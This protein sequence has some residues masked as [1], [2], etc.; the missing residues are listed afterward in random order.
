MAIPII[1]AI[2]IIEDNSISGCYLMS[3]HNPLTFIVKATYTVAS[4]DTI[5]AKIG[6]EVYKCIYYGDESATERLFYFI[7]DEI[8]RADLGAIE[9][10]EQ[11]PDTIIHMANLS[12]D[13]TVTFTE[14]FGIH[15]ISDSVVISVVNAANDF[16]SANGAVMLSD[17]NNESKFYV[18]SKDKQIYLYWYNDNASNVVDGNTYPKG[19]LRKCLIFTECEI[20]TASIV[21]DSVTYTHTVNIKEWYD[22]SY[23]IKYLDRSGKY[24]FMPFNPFV[25]RQSNPVLIG[26]VNELVYS[27]YTSKSDKRSIGYKN[28]DTITMTALELN[29]NE[30]QYL[31]D[32][33]C[34]SDIQLLIGSKWVRV[35][36][37][38][39]NISYLP[40]RRTK[41]VVITVNLP[42]SY[43]I[44]EL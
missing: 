19:F 28:S 6:S 43:N 14:S 13:I 10:Y 26:E 7:A 29:Q 40:K 39:D 35:T 44:T 33:Y 1:S 9:D 27:I 15:T 12:K 24:R 42:K 38:G 37:Q 8:L 36:I 25:K 4:P 17:F 21:I 30:L 18:S 41:D 34:S 22:Y 23:M 3:I 11:T 2:E 20:S 16:E 31:R 5:Y 32:L